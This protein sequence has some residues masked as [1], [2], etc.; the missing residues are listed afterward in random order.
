MAA[1]GPESWEDED[2]L[3]RPYVLTSGR[4]RRVDFDLDLASLIVATEEKVNEAA[5]EPEQLALLAL[6]REPQ[7]VAELSARL[8]IPVAVVKVLLRDLIGRDYARARSPQEDRP[9]QDL[10]QSVLTGLRRL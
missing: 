4:D 3:V 7:S 6:C 1:T 2:A 10:L 5:L 9:D 8:D